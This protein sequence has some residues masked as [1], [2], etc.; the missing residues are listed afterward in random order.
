[1]RIKKVLKTISKIAAILLLLFIILVLV[2]SIPA[3]QTKLGKYAT[4][5][6]NEDYNTNI[7]I[8][9]VG[10]Q[11]NGDVEFK[12]IFIEDH[13]KDTL[14]SIVE[15][16]TSILSLK[17]FYNSK[18]T[19]GEIDIE[20]LIFNL[21]TY[22]DE[23]E[24]NLDVF[25][26]K[27]DDDKPRTKKSNFLLSSSDVSIYNGEFRLIDENKESQNIL[28]FNDLNINATN[29]VVNGPDVN[30]RINT[31][32]FVDGKGLQL[33]NM[34]TDFE[35]TLS[36]MDFQNLII[37]TENSNL[38]GNIRFDFKREDLQYFE[39]KVQV[40]ANF[41]D[42]EL[43]LNDLNTFYN[44]FG[45]NQR[46]KFS[47]DLSGTLNN[48]NATN[49]KLNSG[50]R[51][52]IYG[53]IVFENLFNSKED[54]F[55]MNGT[56]RN[57]SSNYYDLQA[58]LPNILG[59]SLPSLFS[60][61][62]NFKITGQSYITSKVIK[63]DIN[64]NT[65][66]GFIKSNLE[67]NKVDDIDNASYKGN[68]VFKD[69]NLGVLLSDPKIET[70]SLNLDVDGK[71]FTIDNLDTQIEGEVFDIIYNG[72][73]YQN[74]NVSGQ[75]GNKIF[76][77]LLV[78]EDKNLK[79]NFN[80]LADFSKDI[81]TYNFK[82]DVGYAN[83]RALNFVTR[84]S[85]SVFKG[86]V[87]MSINATSIDDASGTIKVINTTY[88]NENSS[89]LFK[90]FTIDSKFKN[91]KRFVTLK[92]PDI[93][94]GT[95][96][97]DFNFGDIRKLVENSVG[98]IF[99][100]YSPHEIEENQYI[101]FDFKIYDKIV[102][103]F[104]NELKLS[105]NT[106]I[107]GRVESNAKQFKLKFNSP[108][109]NL[110]KYFA[111]AITLNIDNSNPVFNTYIKV[112]SLNTKYYNAS[113]FNLINIT[114][115]D[116]LFVKTEFK[117]GENNKDEFDLNLFYTIN[118]D[119]KFVVGFKK[120][121]I[122]FKDYD[123]KI[124]EQKNKLNK[125]T[126]DKD[127]KDF[128]IDNL[129]ISH[130]SEEVSLSGEIIGANYKNLKL[131]FNDVDL[132]KIT[133]PIDS[134]SLAGNINGNLKL[135]Q[136]EGVYL[137]SSD[138]TIDNLKVNKYNLGNLK[139][140]V[141]GNQSL[142]NYK[143][144]IKLQNDNLKTFDAEGTLD[145]NSKNPRI[146]VDVVFDEF[147]LDPLNPLGEGVI[148]DIRGLVSGNAK[149][150][151]SL[152]KPSIDGQLFLDKA[153]LSIPYLNIDYSFDFDSKVRL[154]KQSFIFQDVALTDSEYFSKGLLNGDISHTNFSNWRL[155]LNLTTD[156]LLVLNTEDSQDALYYGTAFISGSASIH[157]PTS[158]LLIEVD[159]ETA[160][161]TVFNIPLND[162]ESFGDNSYIHF[163]TPEEKQARLTG[164]IIEEKQ[165]TGLELK[166]DLNVNQ[167][168][169]IEI[170]I[171]KDSG[172]TIKGKGE[173]VLLFEINT[174]GKF[175]MWGDFSVFE[176]VYNFKYGALIQKEFVV[177]PGGSIE[178]EGDPLKAQIDL[179]AIYKTTANPSVLLDNPINRSIPVDVEINLT[180]QL[181]QP[182][183]SFNLEFPNVDSTIKSELSYR[184]ES[185]DER[186]KQA[187]YLLATGS[188]SRGINDIPNISGTIA[189][190]LNGIVNSFF[191]D[192]DGK[193]KLGFNYEIG[194]NRPDFQ[195]DDRFGLT[196]QTKISDKVIING[197]VGIPI[198]GASETVIAG[199]VQ[200][201]FLL[202]DEGTL[203]AK[204]FNRENN[205]RNFGEEIGYTQGL[206]LSYNVEFD[207]FKEL[208]Q[209][210]FSGKNK[211]DK[212][213]KEKKKE[214]EVVKDENLPDFITMK[215]KKSDE[216]QN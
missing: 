166:F 34:S 176:G 92:S 146:N 119:N 13:K 81:K 133:P 148:N 36:N 213:E 215:K 157:G 201:D 83:L 9:K 204:V 112:D 22:K 184:L 56:F 2:F 28:R 38:K 160:S 98:S 105:K 206:G 172:S 87:E 95:I 10:L 150:S 170:V 183:P 192:Q 162:T 61:V 207:T 141:S 24:T 149:V 140:I 15:L 91:D 14:I 84:D 205:I 94:E 65:E 12:N 82:A 42:S 103:V 17:N 52:K 20:G 76:N 169:E 97:G 44:E 8:S 93:I 118:E 129:I 195:T 188:F 18:L 130:N 171:D 199:D 25:V 67:M 29:F 113:S 193:L 143:V 23:S 78:S 111:N 110:D 167:N 4:N 55:S 37:S 125:V 27:F 203:R 50:R 70:T 202:N 71:G 73:Q 156:R 51:T 32:S 21:K 41:K 102:S 200:I 186:E 114:R 48:L 106:T 209:I 191:G 7:S 216:T 16:N 139:A 127:L 89:Y 122:R 185:S 3:V 175:D 80:G 189:E 182:Q 120:S 5:W 11:F 1:M 26:A 19:F 68:I 69:F 131:N 85:I 49:L 214:Q 121:N 99:T 57:L 178:W 136:N 60:K 100:N 109:I 187:L 115:R 39:D 116:T 6:I 66:I 152:N 62:G 123:W 135:L 74:I 179:K 145:F 31:L 190:R 33:K 58:M 35:Y 46:A 132:V 158:Q 163:L 43:F 30:T 75:L 124:N 168:A 64:I 151:G 161:G 47:V 117:G 196:L 40:T 211:K 173:G 134:L 54:N 77:G 63:A 53:D 174:N 177:E 107:R 108:Q 153:G 126:F 90:N 165:I 88:K 96:T 164:Q 180:G 142:T 104:Y 59:K 197:K 212:K 198:G 72:Y 86:N 138:L 101:D 194:Q 181:E 128:L 208:L 210:I 155:G 79:L 144:D 154:E 159:G 137:P 45:K 147:L